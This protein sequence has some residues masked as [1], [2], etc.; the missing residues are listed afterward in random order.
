MTFVSCSICFGGIDSVLLDAARLGV[1]SMAVV[2]LA[3][4]TAFA[5]WFVRLRALER[6]DTR[7]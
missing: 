5:R 1:L 2:T 4:L 3:V 7:R 6:E